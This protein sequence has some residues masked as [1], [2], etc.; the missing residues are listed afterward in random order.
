MWSD[1][2]KEKVNAQA[3]VDVFMLCGVY[4]GKNMSKN[5]VLMLQT[6]AH[7]YFCTTVFLKASAT[8]ILTI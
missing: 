1:A 8:E 2:K 7:F 6:I 5:K 4:L 3:T